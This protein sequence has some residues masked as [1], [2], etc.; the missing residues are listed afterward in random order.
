MRIGVTGHRVL[1]EPDRVYKAVEDLLSS[2]RMS[3]ETGMHGRGKASTR[4]QWKVISPLATGADRIVARV[5]MEKLDASLDVVLP[6]LPDEYRRDFKDPDDLEEFNLLFEKAANYPS[7]TAGDIFNSPAVRDGYE[8]A[9]KTLVDSCEILIAVWDGKRAR[10]QGGTASIVSYAC[11]VNRLVVWINA[12]NPEAPPA[13]VVKAEEEAG[14]PAD[15]VSNEQSPVTRALPENAS[16]WSPG[17]RQVEEYNSDRGFRKN[18]YDDVLLRNFGKLRDVA[19]KSGLDPGTLMPLVSALLP[20]FSRADSLAIRYRKLHTTSAIW[21]Y[22]LAAF[23]VT[24]AVFQ[25][26]FFTGQTGWTV[27][28]LLALTGAIVMFRVSIFRRWHEKYLNYRHL[29]E[30][31]RILLFQSV[32]GHQTRMESVLREALP[33]YPGPGGWVPDV[34]SELKRDLPSMAVPEE[35]FSAVRRFVTEGW[36]SDQVNYHERNASVKERYSVRDR[37]IIFALLAGT[38]AAGLVHLSK[39]VHDPVLESFIISLVI[40]LPS[41]ASAQHA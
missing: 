7:L 29:A 38:L 41:F 32:V 23:S 14:V 16:G 37:R 27:L 40:I 6:A 33:F 10:G 1:D 36:V 19:E 20:H 25:T 12:L 5:A 24:V 4:V 21:L 9:G 34:V 22:R 3:F 18:R 35:G 28:E 11:S 15:S 2:I 31:I 30:R 39:L 13:L 26:L 8:Q 17:F